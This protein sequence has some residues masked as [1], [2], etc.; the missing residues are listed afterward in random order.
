MDHHGHICLTDFGLSKQDMDKSSG[1]LTFCGTAEYIAPELLKGVAYG[2][3]VDWWSY[4]ILIY[5]MINGRTPF[6]DKNKKLMYYRIMHNRP[7]FPSDLFTADAAEIILGLLTVDEK[8]RLGSNGAD[9]IK[10]MAFFSDVNFDALM[11]R[12]VDAPW[13]PQGNSVTGTSYVHM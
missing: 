4:G 3:E 11:S 9:D 10:K 13:M 6:Y 8:E 1:A 5:E 2:V 7:Q 12:K